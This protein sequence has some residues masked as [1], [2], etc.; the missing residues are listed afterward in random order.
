[1]AQA[2]GRCG[3]KDGQTQQRAAVLPR[4]KRAKGV[5]TVPLG[6]LPQHNR[7][8]RFERAPGI[9]NIRRCRKRHGM[10]RRPNL[11]TGEPDEC[12]T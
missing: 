2:C 12:G 1:M 7:H 9:R 6:L 3:Q 11:T 5:T 8:H 4:T 10:V